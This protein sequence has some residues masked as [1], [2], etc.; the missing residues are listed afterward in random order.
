MTKLPL[1]DAKTLEKV[2][3]KAGFVKVRQRGS[4]VFYRHPD[5]FFTTIP[6]HPG[7]TIARPLLKVILKEADISEERYIALLDQI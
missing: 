7:R 5:G 1:V 6:H 4:H 3:Y 2:L